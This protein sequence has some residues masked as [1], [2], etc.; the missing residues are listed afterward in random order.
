MVNDIDIDDIELINYQ[1]I[2]LINALDEIYTCIETINEI[3]NNNIEIKNK[4]LNEIE[5]LNNN[6]KIIKKF[7]PFMLA[8]YISN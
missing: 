3:K 7:M 4:I 5:N 8:Y 1:K 2:K 6:N